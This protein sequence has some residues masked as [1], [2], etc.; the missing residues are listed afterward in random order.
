MARLGVALARRECPRANEVFEVLV[1]GHRTSIEPVA[2]QQPTRMKDLD[3]CDPRV[4]PPSLPRGPLGTDHEAR[5]WVDAGETIDGG[6]RTCVSYARQ[7]GNE[8]MFD[9]GTGL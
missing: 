3:N 6:P 2:P 7:S 1:L 8:H 4:F 9:S 5:R